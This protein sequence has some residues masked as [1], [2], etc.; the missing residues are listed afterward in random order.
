MLPRQIATFVA[1]SSILLSTAIAQAQCSKDTDCKGD[2][3]CDAGKCTAL[4]PAPPPPPGAAAA[5]APAAPATAPAAGATTPA[6]APPPAPAAAPA[7]AYYA[8]AAPPPPPVVSK[9][10]MRR[11]SKGMMAGGIVLTSLAPVAL[12]VSLVASAEKSVCSATDYASYDSTTGTYSYMPN[13]N[14]CD[15]YDKTIYGGLIAGLV[16]VGAGIP[17]I[18]IGAKKE[19]ATDTGTATL[20]PWATPHA[21]GLSLHLEL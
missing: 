18:V 7:P 17:M 20:S 21:A 13:G 1:G 8:S 3:V 19:P 11:H 5:P 4:P 10:P 16:F 14:N 9:P 12:L 2:R 6:A 15:D